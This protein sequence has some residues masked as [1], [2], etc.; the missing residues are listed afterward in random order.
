MTFDL[1]RV[2]KPSG[3]V[4]ETP[5]ADAQEVP[6]PVTQAAPMYSDLR[7]KQLPV[8]SLSV[9]DTLEYRLTLKDSNADCGHALVCDGLHLRL[10]VEEEVLEVRVP[11]DM[12]SWLRA[13]R[14][15]RR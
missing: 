15:S 8:K 3:R 4:I 13:R 9:G 11:R 14:C 6:L 5:P 12:S 1:V 10:P 2:H 7:T